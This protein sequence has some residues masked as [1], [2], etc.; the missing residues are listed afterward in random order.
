ML[1]EI[2]MLKNYPPVNLNRDDSGAPKSCYFGGV[3]RGRISS[4]CLKR[5][6]RTS[7][8]FRALGSYG[9]RTRSMP[10]L[11]G[12][13]LKKLGIAD[14]LVEEAERKLTGVANKDGTINKKGPITTQI[15]FY[16]N[17]EIDRITEAVKA[18]IEEDGSLK[19][20][21]KRSP[22]DFD[23]LKTCVEERPIT[24]DIA[25]FG[26]MVTSNYFADVDA[27][28]QVAHAISTHALAR[29]SDYFTA[30]DDILGQSDDSSGAGMIGDTDYNSCCYYEYAALDTDILRE[31]LKNCEDRETLIDRL[32]PVLL[33]AMA[34]ANPSGKQNTFAGQVLPDLVMVECKKDKIPLSYVNA[35]EEPVST[36]G[37]QP[38]LVKTS[39]KKLAEHVNCMDHAYTLPVKHRGFFA[40]RYADVHPDNCEVYDQFTTIAEVCRAWLQE[41]DVR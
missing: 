26:R 25:L 34:Y 4:Q 29:E 38:N 41:D 30:V 20:F 2:H 24:V 28:M 18:A 40:P 36:W 19:V 21:S 27:A 9:I 13:R 17:A 14:E 16:S 3:Q 1:I 22:K 8:T 37:N 32:V 6:W 10:A 5:S 31:N 11:V 23:Q 15:V 7:D 39:M 33:R 35:F 12:E